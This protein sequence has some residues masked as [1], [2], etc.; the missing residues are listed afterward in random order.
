MPNLDFNLGVIILLRGSLRKSILKTIVGDSETLSL[1]QSFCLDAARDMIRHIA[2]LF[3]L[4]PHLRAWSYYC[5]YCLQAALVILP[6]L[7][8]ENH[9]SRIS[10]R[11]VD[12]DDGSH[13]THRQPEND[14]EVC[15]LAVRVFEQIELKASQR[16]AE[17]VKQ[18]LNKWKHVKPTGSPR[19]M[20][21]KKGSDVHQTQTLWNRTKP[22]DDLVDCPD[23][24]PSPKDPGSRLAN[25]PH[26]LLEEYGTLHF[27]GVDGGGITRTS[28]ASLT[29]LRDELYGAFYSHN[30][31]ENPGSAGQ[32]YAF[33]EDHGFMDSST[34][35]TGTDWDWASIMG[36]GRGSM[37]MDIGGNQQPVAHET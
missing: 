4:V 10:R 12:G 33:D 28:P 14:W 35:D 22:R 18:F 23:I 13:S 37:E 31:P 27:D 24:I 9:L 15:N 5:F 16:C 34:Q 6:K 30:G 36:L 1:H 17:V 11:S 29:G 8:G 7:A 25:E 2:A 21:S 20:A 19:L 26:G 32:L 3:E